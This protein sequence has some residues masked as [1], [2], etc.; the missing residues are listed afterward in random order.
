MLRLLGKDKTPLGL[1][2]HCKDVC[3][4]SDLKTGL[5]NLSF[6]YP[7]TD[8]LANKVQGECYIQTEDYEFVVKR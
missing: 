3:V 7:I 6:S 8:E 2:V 1:L 4:E 5:K